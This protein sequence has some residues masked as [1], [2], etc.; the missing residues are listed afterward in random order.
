MGKTKKAK[1]EKVEEK[2]QREVG[3]N[4]LTERKESETC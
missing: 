4:Q 3:Q 1:K 2:N